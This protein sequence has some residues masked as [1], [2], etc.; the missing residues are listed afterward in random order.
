MSDFLI[1]F[2]GINSSQVSSIVE[3]AL[4]APVVSE[5]SPSPRVVGHRSNDELLTT[6]LER[7]YHYPGVITSMAPATRTMVRISPISDAAPGSYDAVVH[8]LRALLQGTSED[9]YF[10][11]DSEP[12]L[13]ARI[14]GTNYIHNSTPGQFKTDYWDPSGQQIAILN[15]PTTAVDFGTL[16]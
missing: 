11:Y 8:L 12:L 13:L 1:V 9:L 7:E 5:S 16:L 6:V 3:Q 10:M 14:N 2:D 4:S 15:L